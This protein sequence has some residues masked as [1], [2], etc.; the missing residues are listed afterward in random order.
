MVSFRE[1]PSYS[2]IYCPKEKQV[3]PLEAKPHPLRAAIYLMV[4]TEFS[5]S[6]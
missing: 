5:V 2:G 6:S 4:N 3:L 1:L